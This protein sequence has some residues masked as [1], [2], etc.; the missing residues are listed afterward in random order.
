MLFGS[1][2]NSDDNNECNAVRMNEWLFV[3]T[4]NVAQV[5]LLGCSL[6]C[7]TLHG[8]V[9]ILTKHICAID[10]SIKIFVVNIPHTNSMLL[11]SA[12]FVLLPCLAV[13]HA[14][15][16]YLFA[17]CRRHFVLHVAQWSWNWFYPIFRVKHQSSPHFFFHTLYIKHPFNDFSH[18]NTYR[19]PTFTLN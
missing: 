11:L 14:Q 19:F 5:R 18:F 10:T 9:F 16:L 1:G 13:I 8:M 7:R 15:T 4:E 12:K 6:S 2:S 3:H 17:Y